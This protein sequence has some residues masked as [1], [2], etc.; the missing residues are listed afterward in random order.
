MLCYAK[1]TI[2]Y[3]IIL[4]HI[5]SCYI[6]YVILFYHIIQYY[7]PILQCYAI[8]EVRAPTALSTALRPGPHPTRRREGSEWML[9]YTL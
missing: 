7:Y 3:Y 2:F 4:Y 5:I 1:F 6:A 8:S 9:G